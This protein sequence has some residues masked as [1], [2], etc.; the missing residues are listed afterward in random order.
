MKSY[1]DHNY[2]LRSKWLNERKTKHNPKKCGESHSF[3][4]LEYEWAEEKVT[5]KLASSLI[6]QSIPNISLP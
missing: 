3:C 2:Y 6:N 5:D 4:N 1:S